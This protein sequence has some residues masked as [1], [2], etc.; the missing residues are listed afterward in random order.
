MPALRIGH[1][2][3]AMNRIK[4]DFTG[5]DT[6]VSGEQTYAGFVWY[7]RKRGDFFWYIDGDGQRS[8]VLAIPIKD[9]QL[10]K[11]SLSHWPI[12]HENASGASWSWDR[13]EDAPTLSPSLHI[14][15]EWHG[16]VTNGQLIE[17]G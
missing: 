15:G 1:E 11:W 5:Y 6:A 12:D 3:I 8:L 2:P 17:A 7:T 14:V 4:G 13:N 16:F 9:K 10:P